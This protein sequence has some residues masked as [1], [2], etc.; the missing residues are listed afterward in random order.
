[1][2]QILLYGNC[3]INAIYKTF[4][5]NKLEYNITLIHCYSTNILE[6]DFLQKIKESDIIITQ[7]IN[8][9]YREKYYL[10][11]SY[12]IQNKK[13]ECK[14]ILFDSC[15]FHFYYFDLTYYSYHNEILHQ[16]IDYHY[17]HLIQ[18][19]KEGKSIDSYINDFVKN[20][21]LKTKEELEDIANESLNQL[22]KR[23]EFNLSKY[24]HLD[25]LYF[26][27][28]Y[29]FM[30]DNYKKKLL[31]YSMNHPTKDVIQYICIKIINILNLKNLNMN[32]EM[33]VLDNPRCILYSC[34]SKVVDFDIQEYQPLLFKEKDIYK[35]A[36][37]YYQTY[38]ELKI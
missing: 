27:S 11:T 4:N 38:E 3:Q 2:I 21:N 8:D 13:K 34:I 25:N 26:I 22:K 23:Y 1:M 16:P 36:E 14:M 37:K 18:Y 31:F 17:H 30:K 19:Y 24:S 20:E 7:T 35:I 5:F 33:D 15:Y 9:N 32:E 10:S 28:I 29:D 12:I 6:D